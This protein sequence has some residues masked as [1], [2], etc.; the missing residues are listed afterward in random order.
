MTK[1][2]GHVVEIAIIL[3]ILILIN[4][5]AS[6][7]FFRWDITADK[8]FTIDKASK[9]LVAN[10]P[11]ELRVTLYTS[12]DLPAQ[13]K[14]IHKKVLDL[15]N[16]YRAYANSNFVFREEH[17]DP[18]DKEEAQRLQMRGIQ[19]RPL[20]AMGGEKFEIANVYLDLLI[21]YGD[22]N[23]AIP[24]LRGS[25]GLEYQITRV[26]KKITLKEVPKIG[27][28]AGAGQKPLTEEGMFKGLGQLLRTEYEVQDVD[29]S[30][31]EKVPEKVSTMIILSPDTFGPKEKIALD[32][33]IM[34]GGKV[35]FFLDAVEI[36]FQEGLQARAKKKPTPWADFIASY[37]LKVQPKL[38]G[39]LESSAGLPLR[40]YMLPVRYPLWPKVIQQNFGDF[41]FT[42]NLE[43]VNL[44]W[45]SPVEYLTGQ[46]GQDVKAGYIFHSTGKAYA[47]DEPFNLDPTQFAQKTFTPPSELGQFELGAMLSGVFKSNFEG[48][49]IPTAPNAE[50]IE[51][52]IWKD[53][54]VTTSAPTDLILIGCSNLVSDIGLNQASAV[55]LMNMVDSLTLGGGLIDLRSRAVT[56][57]PLK[58]DLSEGEKT[59]IKF[60]GIFLIPILISLYGFGRFMLRIQTKKMVEAKTLGVD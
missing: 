19:A 7:Y 13:G 40:G 29:L 10:L 30:R 35:I 2:T 44:P 41:A 57:R 36:P 49:Q 6:G 32:Q 52:P 21:S 20:Q 54:L 4:I 45:A 18:E 17:P 37:G 23:E 47:M 56:D 5:L 59:F 16:E 3:G 24:S 8:Q 9:E 26:I 55:F 11:D 38:V 12:P 22:K 27:V 1:A 42:S 43:S 33:F 25:T 14:I 51:E 15:I 31:G 58:A 48:K 39:D 53:E 46:V 28:F 34:R 60:S 50:G